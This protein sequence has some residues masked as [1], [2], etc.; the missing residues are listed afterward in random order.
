MCGHNGGSIYICPWVR[1]PKILGTH[2]YRQLRCYLTRCIKALR[3][4]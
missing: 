1:V 4:V 3:K 2:G